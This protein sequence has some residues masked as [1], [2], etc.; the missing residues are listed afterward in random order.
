[1]P[2]APECEKTSQH[3]N[4]SQ[5][6]EN[7]VPAG[8]ELQILDSVGWIPAAQHVVPLQNLMQHNAVEKTSQAEAEEDAGRDREEARWLS[9]IEHR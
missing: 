1:M 7:A 9:R 4:I 5:G 8:I 2:C 3:E 6:M